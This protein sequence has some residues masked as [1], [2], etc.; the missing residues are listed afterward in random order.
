MIIRI[1][2]KT[3]M[4]MLVTRIIVRRV[5]VVVVVVII[6]IIIMAIVVPIM[7]N[8]IVQVLAASRHLCLA[9]FQLFAEA[10]SEPS[11]FNR[12]F[13]FWELQ[14]LGLAFL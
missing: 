9:F 6:V 12:F 3:A 11:F 10:D 8:I 14:F 4:V 13:S 2:F 7:R 5:A 1:L